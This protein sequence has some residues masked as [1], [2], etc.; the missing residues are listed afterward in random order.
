MKG[1]SG[2]RGPNQDCL[3]IRNR[4]PSTHGKAIGNHSP[5]AP[6]SYYGHNH[7]TESILSH[8]PTFTPRHIQVL[9][10][11]PKIKRIVWELPI[12][13]APFDITWRRLTCWRFSQIKQRDLQGETFMDV[14]ANVLLSTHKNPTSCSHG[15][16]RDSLC[17]PT[18]DMKRER[19][20]W[21]DIHEGGG[22]YSEHLGSISK[23]RNPPS[24]EHQPLNRHH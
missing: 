1:T 16:Y 11:H 18:L 3:S 21:R 10:G 15:T 5:A 22:S 20:H 4:S 2:E 17:P 7:S 23:D 13:A 24:D 12:K 14:L 9:F 19:H 8:I 6:F